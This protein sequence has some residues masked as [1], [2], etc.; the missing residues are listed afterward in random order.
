MPELVERVPFGG[1]ARPGGRT[2]S[3]RIIRQGALPL[4][5]E[6]GDGARGR[7]SSRS[8]SRSSEQVRTVTRTTATPSIPSIS[9]TRRTAR[10]T[11]HQPE[12]ETRPRVRTETHTAEQQP[13][14]TAERAGRSLRRIVWQWGSP[15]TP[16]R[17][18]PAR[19]ATPPVSPNTRHGRRW[20][21]IPSPAHGN[22]RSGQTATR[23]QPQPVPA[24]FRASARSPAAQ[25]HDWRTPV[26]AG[27]RA[28][29]AE[30]QP[31]A[32]PSLPALPVNPARWLGATSPPPSA[33]TSPAAG[34]S[35]SPSTSAGHR[36]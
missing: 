36:T 13:Q 3:Q 17:R 25:P 12:S 19:P 22:E 7:S 26:R 28:V 2:S 6:H 27:R 10:L 5:M 29:N 30:E 18:P 24:I 11:G 16:A 14:V 4:R 20:E 32:E 1:V 31:G 21:W 33:P 8:R 9:V 34:P 15:P 35:T 23:H